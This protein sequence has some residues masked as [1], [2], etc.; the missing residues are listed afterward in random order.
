MMNEKLTKDPNCGYPEYIKE[1]IDRSKDQN[2][3]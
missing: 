1:Y 3:G 2:Y